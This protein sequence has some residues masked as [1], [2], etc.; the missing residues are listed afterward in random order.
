MHL[1][2]AETSAHPELLVVKAL[3]LRGN[4]CTFLPTTRRPSECVICIFAALNGGLRLLVYIVGEHVENICDEELGV[5]PTVRP[6]A[7]MSVIIHSLQ[8]TGHH[9]RL[10]Q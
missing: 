5:S 6:Q 8:L 4:D 1:V 9:R 2:M 10:D 7:L 3:A